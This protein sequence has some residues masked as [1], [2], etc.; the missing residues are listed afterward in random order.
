MDRRGGVN[1][2]GCTHNAKFGPAKYQ[3]AGFSRRRVP[4]P[5]QPGK[6]LPEPRYHLCLRDGYVVRTAP[7]VKLLGVHLDRE[8]RWHQQDTAAMAKGEAW[9]IQTGR[10]ARASRGIGAR[11]MRRLYLGVCIPRMLY[12]ADVFLSPPAVN[13][14]LLA[15]FVTGE[16]RER[17]VVKKLR[18]IQRCAA[19]AITGA[20]RTTPTDVL[21][22]Y[23]NLLPA[24][25]LID[26]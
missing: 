24:T 8:L 21:D 13:R 17:A 9:L 12:A 2:W 1:E 19:L 18:S 6:T 4:A 10:I 26:K 14:S 11:N 15:Q 5:F 23:A 16:R 3:V 20:L 22:A 7:S 25:H